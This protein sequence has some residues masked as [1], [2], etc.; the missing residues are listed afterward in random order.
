[1]TYL[2]DREKFYQI[3]LE[4]QPEFFFDST[5]GFDWAVN[6]QPNIDVL[7]QSDS[8][9][10]SYNLVYLLNTTHNHSSIE[11]LSGFF[12]DV[13]E[14]QRPSHLVWSQHIFVYVTLLYIRYIHCIFYF[15]FILYIFVYVLS[16]IQYAMYWP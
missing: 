12:S 10:L 6:I 13:R 14:L 5:A 3:Y 11:V 16:H 7:S 1:M 2:S 9:A 8:E 4:E 15:L